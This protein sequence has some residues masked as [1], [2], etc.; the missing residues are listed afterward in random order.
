MK[1]Y[2]IAVRNTLFNLP[3]FRKVPEG[4]RK[5]IRKLTWFAL[6]P[7]SRKV[8][9]AFRKPIRKPVDHP[10]RRGRKQPVIHIRF[11][12]MFN[13]RGLLVFTEVDGPV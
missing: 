4:F 12:E 8:P 5:P 6:L 3:Q 2:N 10:T 1:S 9:E 11:P 7:A 13:S